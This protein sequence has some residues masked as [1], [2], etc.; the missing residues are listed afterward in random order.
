MEINLLITM[1]ILNSSFILKKTYLYDSGNQ[2]YFR[3]IYNIFLGLNLQY[4]WD[5]LSCKRGGKSCQTGLM[6]AL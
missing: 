6:H 3:I 1:L 2:A 5:I 4:I